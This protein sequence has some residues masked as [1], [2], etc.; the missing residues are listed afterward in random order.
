MENFYRALLDQA[1]R[2]PF[3]LP[4]AYPH[5]NPDR[6]GQVEHI[7]LDLTFDI[8]NKSYSGT[9]KVTIMPVI[10][11]VDSLM[12]DAVDLNIHSVKV[13]RAKQNFEYDGEQI[14]VKLKTPTTAGKAFTL[15]I[16]YAVENPQRGIYFVGPDEHYPDKPTQVWTQ[17]EDEDSRFWFPC[18]DYPGQLATSEIRAKVPK[19]FKVVS[20]GELI[21]TEAAGSA[22]IYHWKL[23]KV[24]PSYLMTL[25]IGEFDEINDKWN[26]WP[27]N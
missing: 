15:T 7:A 13:G 21:A 24:H 12:M 20:N 9:S 6:P 10:D 8:P 23:E 22:K 19:K 17:G 11:G 5:Y 16:D 3:E 14:K 18:F 4:G 1:G 27:V 25:A 26:G 2:K